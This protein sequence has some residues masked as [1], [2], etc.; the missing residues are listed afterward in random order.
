MEE[1]TMEYL[2]E[3]TTKLKKLASLCQLLTDEQT[4]SQIKI[5]QK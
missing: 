5:T 3:I 2:E 1:N 4:K